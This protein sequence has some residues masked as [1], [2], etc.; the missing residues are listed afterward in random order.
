MNYFSEVI[1]N[2][3]ESRNRKHNCIPLGFKRFE[4]DLPGIIKENYTIITASSGVG[5]SKL[6]LAKYVI[7]PFKFV[8]EEETD[9][10]AKIFV[11]ALEESKQK[12]YLSIL[13]YLLYEK[14]NIEISVK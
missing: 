14:Y 7:K 5:K 1:K 4:E 2:I 13:S 11:F 8:T 9:I 6:A 10:D 12:F 3:D